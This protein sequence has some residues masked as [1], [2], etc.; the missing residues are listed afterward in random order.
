MITYTAERLAVVVAA[1]FTA[2][3]FVGAAVPVLPVA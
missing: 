3:L 1:L 2:A